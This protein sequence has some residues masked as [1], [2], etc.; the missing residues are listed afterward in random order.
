MILSL[1][2]KE[3]FGSLVGRGATEQ[4]SLGQ[5]LLMYVKNKNGSTEEIFLETQ[6]VDKM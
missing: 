1:V 2:L 6:F 3:V 5:L 4:Q